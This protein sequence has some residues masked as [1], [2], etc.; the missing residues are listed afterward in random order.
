[1]YT[2]LI[3]EAQ[4]AIIE[5][6]IRHAALAQHQPPS[7]RRTRA[8]G[9]RRRLCHTGHRR[10]RA[11]VGL[12]AL[13][14]AAVLTF[15][16]SA[17]AALPDNCVAGVHTVVCNYPYTGSEQTFTVPSGV[18]SVQVDAVGAAGGGKGATPGGVA[19]S[20]TL[21]LQVRPGE[22]LYV[23]VGGAG[24]QAP[25]TGPGGWNGGGTGAAGAGGGGGSSDVR[26]VPCGAT[27]PGND[28]SL[29]SRL[30]VAAGGG[31]A[32]A[33][34]LP[35]AGGAA[36]HAGG[37]ATGSGGIGGA[38]GRLGGGGRGGAGAPSNTPSLLGGAGID[39]TFG[40]GGTGAGDHS[41][42]TGFGGG[43]GG[44]Y[45]GGGGGGSGPGIG[46]GFC[47]TVGGVT[48]CPPDPAGGGGGGGGSSYA[49]GGTINVD[50]AG[51]PTFVSITY[52]FSEASPSQQSVTFAPQ[53]QATLSPSQ[54]LTITN[55]GAASLRVTGLTFSGADAG[56]FVVT[57]D[58]CRGSTID[59]GDSCVVNVGFAP[60]AA[61]S[62][63]AA[64][65]IESNDPLNPASVALSG[66]GSGLA[67]GPQGPAGPQGQTG[68]A[69]AQ[70]PIGP[71]GP[72]G[73]PGAAG[74][75]ICNN[76]GA[77]QLLCSIIF[78]PGTWSTA[79]PARLASYDISRHGRT[80]ESGTIRV[81]HGQVTLRS[82][83]LPA[84]RYALTVTIGTGHHRVTLLHRPVIIPDT[85]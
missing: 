34:P 76:S 35:G 18:D 65:V 68:S 78:P 46:N 9:L 47:V 41:A 62:R 31:G 2:T 20:A 30:V 53:P 51:D 33:G 79:H 25:G 50:S 21:A 42:D 17:L 23:E 27:C 16:S 57:S 38:A 36:D 13:I 70:G 24:L 58:D 4:K 85:H 7:A 74:K 29:G 44:G 60:Q 82:R 55:T 39:G 3:Y 37:D 32:G 73:P 14:G 56:D 48:T 49:P 15:A 45:F 40:Q 54:P 75:V 83:P 71:T 28:V 77:A 6:R 69:G 11:V 59:A 5:E 72:Q 10:L 26:T 12:L 80:F 63:S 64:L 61:G 52:G 8:R 22:V 66:T 67:A 84:G 19:A 1:M 43:G 81:G